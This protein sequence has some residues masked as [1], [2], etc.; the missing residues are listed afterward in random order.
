MRYLLI[1]FLFVACNPSKMGKSKI[2]KNGVIESGVIK[3]TC[4]HPSKRYTKAIDI[5]VKQDFDSLNILP[6]DKL[7]IG[8]SQTVTRLSDYSTDGLD[9]DLILFRL[10][11]ISLNKGFTSEQ[12]DVLV[13]TTIDAWSKKNSNK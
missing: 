3:P 10:C 13:K 6:F 12:T 7:N 8:I 1:L 9:L 11:E 4:T 5:K 2:G